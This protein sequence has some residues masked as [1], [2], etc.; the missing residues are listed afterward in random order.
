MNMSEIVI[1]LEETNDRGAPQ[2]TVTAKGLQ[3]LNDGLLCG[4]CLEDLRPSGAFPDECPA[5]GFRVK[6]FQTQQLIQDYKGHQ[7]VGSRISLSEE[8]DRLNVWR[9]GQEF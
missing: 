3:M 5:C 7:R 9:P 1:E 6:E 4:R 2:V 8:L